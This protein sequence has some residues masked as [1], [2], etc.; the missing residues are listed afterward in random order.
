M[1]TVEIDRSKL[2]NMC[3]TILGSIHRERENMLK[4]HAMA[5]IKQSWWDK[6]LGRKQES[7]ENAL[8]YLREEDKRW[9]FSQALNGGNYYF[10]APP[11]RCYAE[12]EETCNKLLRAARLSETRIVVVDVDDLDSLHDPGDEDAS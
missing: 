2:I 9:T 3:K 7:F 11:S 10:A 8:E 5:Y 4:H 12:Q 6:L 1:S